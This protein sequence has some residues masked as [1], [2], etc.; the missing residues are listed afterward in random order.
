[1]T[2]ITGQTR[3][4][5]AS[6]HEDTLL[7]NA[8]AIAERIERE[9][10]PFVVK[11]GRYI[12]NEWGTIHKEHA[13][14]VKVCLAFPEAYEL[15][16]SYLG[17]AILGNLINQQDDCLAER[18]FAPWPDAEEQLRKAGLPLFSLESFTP[19]NEFDFIGFSLSY[20][21]LYTNVLTMLDLGG[22]PLRSAARTEDDPIV[23]AGGSIVYNPEPVAAFFDL[24]LIGDG[25]DAL[26]EMLPILREKRDGKID[27]SEA[28]ARLAK[29]EGVYHPAGYKVEYDASG[30]FKAIEPQ[31]EDRPALVKSRQS[32]ELKN[33]NYPETPIVPFIEI[34]HD[35]LSVEIMRGCVRN[36]RFCQAGYIYLPKRGRTVEDLIRHVVDSLNSSGWDE[37]TLLSLLS[38]DFKGLE[39]LAGELTERLTPKR[40]S[41][42]LP[43]IRPGTF[44]ID[45]AKKIAQVR[46]SGLTFAPEAGSYRMRR[47]INKMISDEDMLENAQ[48][49]FENGWKQ[50]KL[51]FMIGLPGERDEDLDAIIELTRKVLAVGRKAGIRPQINITVSPFS[52]KS[53]TPFQWE[54]Q[55]PVEEIHR[56][57]AYLKERVKRLPV[58]LKLRDPR[59]SFLE[60]VL[61][62]SDRRVA[63]V[64]ETAWRNGARFDAWKE[65]FNFD[66][67]AQA[68]DE[69]GIDP[70]QFS[71][72]LKL[73]RTLP[74]S[75]ID[76]GNITT[77]F[78]M[79]QRDRAM[80][81][82]ESTNDQ[83]L[84][85]EEMPFAANPP[86]SDAEPEREADVEIVFPQFAP[87]ETET[88]STPEFG[89]RPR[90]Q[91]AAANPV[92]PTRSKIR[93]RWSKGAPVRFI[94]HLDCLRTMERSIRRA[95]VPVAF[96]E[97]F[98]PHL[99]LS[100][101]PPL[102]LGFTSDDEYLD[103]QTDD[104]FTDRMFRRLQ[105]SL[106]RGFK[107]LNY[108][109]VYNT[110]ESL[111]AMLNRATYHVTLTEDI[112]DAL[113]QV[114]QFVEAT[115]V[116]V[117]R[118]KKQKMVNI[119]PSVVSL[120]STHDGPDHTYSF[121]L[122]LGEPGVAKPLEVLASVTSAHEEV[123]ARARVTRTQLFIERGGRQYSPLADC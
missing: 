25:E 2:T 30:A 60:G 89:R 28:I 42:S 13:G 109:P 104:V 101:G 61:G 58:R 52:P 82:A 99:K 112:P 70:H 114:R 117:F 66:K 3:L 79:R 18:V 68:F 91:P 7:H 49:A 31:L 84:G 76:K 85:K 118:P 8:H 23:M 100:F 116:E 65:W 24:F 59:V 63:D 90:R 36:C 10:L 51:Y 105:N 123:I 47:V 110:R 22:I 33:S 21:L 86:Q 41:I 83:P 92:S 80:E 93:I 40:I 72:S 50:I 77:E 35:R 122:K 97:G 57:N 6:I 48:T 14:R 17:T 62:R 96:T 103:L 55:I 15:G 20:E 12:G 1:L 32:L 19:L 119:R 88:E 98:N 37:V 9:F 4:S 111:A 69:V 78:L 107:L 46:R 38:T 73:D 16:M 120:T 26:M 106:P 115:E 56:K 94:S 81:A 11:P 108:L 87:D 44:S 54:A 67:W 74:W 5:P 113:D 45:M 27:R 64:I 34:T 75:H 102:S 29:I 121:T 53:H 39:S 95:D 71:G 43:S